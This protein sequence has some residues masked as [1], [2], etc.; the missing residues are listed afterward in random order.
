MISRFSKNNQISNFVKIRPVEAAFL[1]A[2]GRTEMTKLIAAFRNFAN[3]PKNVCQNY[4]P[5]GVRSVSRIMKTTP[6][7]PFT[8]KEMTTVVLLNCCILYVPNSAGVHERS[9][10]SKPST[11][12]CHHLPLAA[13]SNTCIAVRCARSHNTAHSYWVAITYVFCCKCN[14]KKCTV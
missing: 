12:T 1:H 2:D 4:R 11:S 8:G 13:A 9:G 14:V 3:V 10:R 7:R 5:T 6:A